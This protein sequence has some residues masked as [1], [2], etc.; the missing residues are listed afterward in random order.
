[1]SDAE[2]L[3]S[4]RAL[5][6]WYI[7]RLE[8]KDLPWYEG[9]SSSQYRWWHAITLIS[10]GATLATSIVAALMQKEF[11]GGDGKVWLVVLPLIGTVANA[12]LSQFRFRELEDL[13]ERGRIEM[14]DIVFYARGQLSAAADDGA[15][16]R[17]YEETRK[18]VRELD[19]GQHRADAEL[20]AGAGQHAKKR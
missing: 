8:A 12:I 9:A 19:L 2:E 14:E 18:R 13:R 15:C 1:M 11:F 7:A 17:A 5:L 10:L 6:R 4:P 16:L 20:R 3:Q